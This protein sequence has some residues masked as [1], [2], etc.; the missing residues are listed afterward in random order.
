MMYVFSVWEVIFIVFLICLILYFVCFWNEVVFWLFLVFWLDWVLDDDVFNYW[1]W[2]FG[3]LNL[4]Y[5]VEVWIV[6]IV[7]RLMLGY[8][9]FLSLLVFVILLFF[10]SMIFIDLKIFGCCCDGKKWVVCFWL[11]LWIE[12]IVFWLGLDGRISCLLGCVFFFE[13]VVFW[14]CCFVG[15][16][17]FI[18]ICKNFCGIWDCCFM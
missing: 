11:N 10:L 9:F 7:Y 14:I 18:G 3:G 16:E 2:F 6:V 8:W 4:I 13:L 1:C 17:I 5:V 12:I 15:I